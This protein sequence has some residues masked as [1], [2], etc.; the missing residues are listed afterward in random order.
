MKKIININL[1][2][3][4]IP[5]ED[6]AYDLLKSYLE[7]LKFHF[8]REEG[9]E[10]IIS[11]IEDRIAEVFQDKLKKG[12]HCITDEDVNTMV[13]IMGR[14]EQ[15]EEETATE[16]QNKQSAPGGTPSARSSK[17]L[18][19]DENDK[20]VGGVCSG[21]AAFLGIDAVVVRVITFILIWVW[22]FGLLIYIVLWIVL[23]SS[24]SI[25]NP[26]HK[27]LY[28]NPDNKVVGGVA[29]G[30]AAYLNIDPV[31]PRVL[32]VLPLLGIIFTSIFRHWMWFPGF[33]LPLSVGFLP[34]LIVLYIILWISVPMAKTVADKL[35]M[36]GEKVDLQS[37][38]NAMKG[39]G[40][41]KKN[42]LVKGS[43]IPAEENPGQVAESTQH[44]T[45]QA[46]IHTTSRSRSGAGVALV[47]LFKVLGYCILALIIAV[48]CLVLVGSAGGFIG[49]AGTSSLILPY[50][51]LILQGTLQHILAW[52]AV[53]LT[54]G[55]PVVAIIWLI[56][57]LITGFRPKNRYVG[58]SL[59]FLWFIGV[60]CAVWLCI[61]LVRDFRMNYREASHLTVQQPKT[62][63][64][65]LSQPPSDITIGGWNVL[66]DFVEIG[67]DTVILKNI[68]LNIFKSR[69]DSFRLEIVRCSN[70]YSVSDA[71]KLARNI[72]FNINQQDSV[73]Y[74]PNGFSLPTRTPFRNQHVIIHLYVPIGGHIRVD[75]NLR[76]LLRYSDRSGSWDWHDHEWRDHGEGLDRWNFDE[77]LRMTPDGLREPDKQITD[78]AYQN[79][80]PLAPPQT[81]S[82]DKKDSKTQKDQPYRYKQASAKLDHKRISVFMDA[83]F[84]TFFYDL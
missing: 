1:S 52:P 24:Q 74:I 83:G 34:T 37:I 78:T 27:R 81:D 2:S 59:F 14:P 55:I 7:D 61:S 43:V 18:L 20:M 22:G 57:K 31:I 49:A 70:G 64:I 69:D 67:D 17:K 3:R 46:P 19:R 50:K 65:L 44:P 38:T 71:R 75:E 26:V 40:E 66:N 73:I 32:L 79:T 25:K 84:S 39:S 12:A 62:G 10:E 21:I 15:L 63:H 23:P 56:I 5:I 13:S 77:D 53:L 47:T 51:G 28:R 29:S 9:G 30:I 48:M 41:E 45:S 6:S 58:V 82:G 33:F 35:E 54:F 68:W 4:L 42:E 8:G 36:R 76:K 16:P 80:M 72:S 60:I 11:D